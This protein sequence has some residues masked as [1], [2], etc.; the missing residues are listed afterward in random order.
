MKDL[1]TA[2]VYRLRESNLIFTAMA[3][4]ETNV[5]AQ[6]YLRKTITLNEDMV[7]AANHE[8]KKMGIA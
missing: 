8:I 3:A 5:A 2:L 7:D 6:L 1:L 4:A